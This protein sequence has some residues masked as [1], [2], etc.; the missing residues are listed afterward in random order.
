MPNHP[1]VSAAPITENL[2]PSNS[3]DAREPTTPLRSTNS[4]T[5]YLRTPDTSPGSEFI[6][7]G[8]PAYHR[9]FENGGFPFGPNASL[10]NADLHG[11]G[12]P[13][14]R[15]RDT[16]SFDETGYDFGCGAGM[17][18]KSP[19]MLMPS[20]G[21]PE[22][23]YGGSDFRFRSHSSD[24]HQGLSHVVSSSFETIDFRTGMS[25][26]RGLTNSKQNPGH[27]P[28]P[29]GSRMMMSQH[30]GI[31]RARGPLQRISATNYRS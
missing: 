11:P 19:H 29:R 13:R 28:T 26:H 2:I 22:G 9:D 14:Y 16:A 4:D 25:G 5:Q 18:G 21:P 7:T 17:L 10:D 6:I 23:A 31:G 8:R 24:G 20:T 27:S 3:I 30:R 1:V 15:G 12:L